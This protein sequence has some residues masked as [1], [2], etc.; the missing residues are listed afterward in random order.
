[1]PPR[2][3]WF[4]LAITVGP[5][6]LVMLIFFVFNP[7][8]MLS[9]YWSWVVPLVGIWSLAECIQA[10]RVAYFILPE[11]ILRQR[12]FG[13]QIL[14]WSDIQAIGQQE[15][16]SKTGVDAVIILF[17]YGADYAFKP[18]LR[19]IDPITLFKRFASDLLKHSQL[20]RSV[21]QLKFHPRATQRIF[22]C[23]LRGTQ[24]VFAASMAS[25]CAFGVCCWSQQYG[26]CIRMQRRGVCRGATEEWFSFVWAH[27]RV[28]PPGIGLRCGGCAD[29]TDSAHYT[30][31]A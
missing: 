16:R 22:K 18:M 30:A 15:L 4:F 7:A 1:M 25:I 12:L 28:C 9:S 11:G 19:P 31:S 17:L 8:P 23:L 29:D 3:G 21:E 24:A 13:R 10:L 20:T 5:V 2:S 14:R 26:S 6:A 27:S